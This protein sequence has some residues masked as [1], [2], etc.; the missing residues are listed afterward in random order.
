MFSQHDR[1][2]ITGDAQHT[3][4]LGTSAHGQTFNWSMWHFDCNLT[5]LSFKEYCL[6]VA[7][8]KLDYMVDSTTQDILRRHGTILSC[9]KMIGENL[10]KGSFHTE[11]KS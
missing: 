6:L 4:T 9:D 1:K 11:K 7:V 3:A 10:F 5:Q 2:R 8:K